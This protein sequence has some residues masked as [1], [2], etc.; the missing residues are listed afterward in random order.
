MSIFLTCI[1]YISS[2]CD[3]ND[4]INRAVVIFDESDDKYYLLK[5]KTY[6]YIKNE[7]EAIY[8]SYDKTELCRIKSLSRLESRDDINQGNSLQS[9]MI[10][11]SAFCK[12]D[13]DYKRIKILSNNAKIIISHSLIGEYFNPTI[14]PNPWIKEFPEDEYLMIKRNNEQFCFLDKEYNISRVI[15]RD[16]VVGRFPLFNGFDFRA[17]FSNSQLFVS[18]TQILFNYNDNNVHRQ[19]LQRIVLDENHKFISYPPTLLLSD[20]FETDFNDR[21]WQKNWVEFV[22]EDEIYMIRNISNMST[23]KV[24]HEILQ[25]KQQGMA[26]EIVHEI[27]MNECYMDKIKWNDRYG[28]LRGGS[29]ALLIGNEYLAFFHSNDNRVHACGLRNY[30]FGAFTFSSEPPFT[31]TGVSQYPIADNNNKNLNNAFADVARLSSVIFPMSFF[32]QDK[33]NNTIDHTLYKPRDHD[34]GTVVVVS[35]GLYDKY[36]MIWRLNLFQLRLS[37]EPIECDSRS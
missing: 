36:G 32:L 31:L 37:L 6:R 14:L 21:N 19:V 1:A 22:Y 7:L 27:Q 16:H 30:Y 12:H 13:N 10:D 11:F 23:V 28:V 4:H 20:S 9:L 24:L 15:D 33:H 3:V 25:R 35:T 18:F 2:E 29:P 26:V 17:I 5:D 34:D 8:L